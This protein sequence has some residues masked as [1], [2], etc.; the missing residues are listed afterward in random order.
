MYIYKKRVCQVTFSILQDNFQMYVACTLNSS[1]FGFLLRFALE[2]CAANPLALTVQY[3][4]AKRHDYLSEKP[5]W[6]ARLQV[7]MSVQ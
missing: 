1:S 3:S 6:R 7:E 4:R 5:Q 2:W